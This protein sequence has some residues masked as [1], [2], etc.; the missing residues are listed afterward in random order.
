MSGGSDS[1]LFALVRQAIR[2][3]RIEVRRSVGAG[4][5]WLIFAA[6]LLTLGGLCLFKFG[7]VGAAILIGVGLVLGGLWNLG[8][9]LLW[10]L[11]RE[12]VL[13][14]D[15]DALIDR[16]RSPAAHYPWALIRRARLSRTTRN[17]SEESATLT[18]ELSEMV[19][20]RQVQIDLMN[21]DHSAQGIFQ[22]IGQRADLQ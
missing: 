15:A 6:I 19:S 10:V 20:E 2:R 12:P 22:I 3:C 9:G 1:G 7:S 5:V 11:D 4:V 8:R 17:G 16:R 13:I 21:L 18:L 14:L